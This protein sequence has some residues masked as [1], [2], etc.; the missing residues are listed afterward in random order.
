MANHYMTVVQ[1]VYKQNKKRLFFYEKTV[2]RQLRPKQIRSHLLP[3]ARGSE[4]ESSTGSSSGSG[5]Q[6]ASP[7]QNITFQ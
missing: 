3:V 2:R 6:L 7:S 4:S 1:A 5:S